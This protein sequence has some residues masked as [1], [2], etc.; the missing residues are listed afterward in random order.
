MNKRFP[1]FR[2]LL[3]LGSFIIV[4]GFYSNHVSSDSIISIPVPESVKDKQVTISLRI[5]PNT[6]PLN[7]NCE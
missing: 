3:L 4:A 6:E 2:F 1:G 5:P 7:R